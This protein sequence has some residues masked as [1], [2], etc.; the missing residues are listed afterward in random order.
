MK[1][2]RR[3]PPKVV[4]KEVRNIHN[5]TKNEGYLNETRQDENSYDSK[6]QHKDDEAVKIGSSFPKHDQ[7]FVDVSVGLTLLANTVD[8]SDA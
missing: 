6:R 1:P 4:N 7:S 8:M 2:A 5:R 3:T